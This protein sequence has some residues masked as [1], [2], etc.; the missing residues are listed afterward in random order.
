MGG[1]LAQGPRLVVLDPDEAGLVQRAQA[2]DREAFSALIGRHQA[3]VLAYGLR[4]LRDEARA[5]DLAQEVFLTFW[6]ERRRY[7]HRGRL[8]PYLLT[9]ARNRA[10]AQHK[11][12]QASLRLATAVAEAPPRAPS[13]PLES[14]ERRQTRARLEAALARLPDERAEAVQLRFVL[15][16]S[17]A[18]IAEITQ[19]AEGT[20]KSR[21][22][23]GLQG[24]R[25][26]LSHER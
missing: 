21:I 18:E 13:T 24:L 5:R 16:L 19:V 9:V 8:L 17:V 2:G 1:E 6:R 4:A 3:A 26:E 22:G 23:R 10:L 15:G 14:A 12:T 25:E 7:V 11:R 20:V